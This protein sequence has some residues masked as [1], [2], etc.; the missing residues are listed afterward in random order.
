MKAA[1]P[2]WRIILL[3]AILKF[4][5]PF[6]LQS[7]AYELQRDEYLYYQQGQH[8]GLGYLENPP[9]L[10]YLGTISSWLGGSEFWIKFWPSLV[11]AMTII[12]TCLLTSE[13]GGKAF[14]QMIAGIGV[15][16]GAYLRMHSLFQPNILDI[17]FWTLAIYFLVRFIKSTETEFLYAFIFSLALGWWSKYSIVFLAA[18]IFIALLLSRYR[19]IF[20]DKKM[21]LAI[22]AGLILILPNVWWQYEHRWPLIHHMEELQATQ[23]RFSSPLAFLADQLLYLVPVVFVWLS[24]LV[25]LLRRKEWSFL[26]W[27]Y[28][29]LV[30]L[31]LA[32]RG[33]SYYS[34]GI[35]P[36]LLA[37]G[38]VS[39]ESWT[40]T[41][42][43]LRLAFTILIAAL[44]VPFVPLLLPIW[45]PEKLAA[46]YRENNLE[47]T[48]LLKWEDQRNHPLPQDFADML[49]W[50]ELTEK[51]E[52]FFKSLPDSAKASTFVNPDNYGQAGAF[53]YYGK[54]DLFKKRT[55]T[56][57]G[58]FILWL[59]DSLTFKNVL[60][61]GSEMTDFGFS[62]HFEKATLVDSVTNKLSRQ[63]GDKI[64]YFQN[65]DT[66]GLRML[67]ER[68]SFLKREFG[69]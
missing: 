5:L 48:G 69:R 17:F 4:I 61:T 51:T 54:E 44:T 8:L 7:S 31:L 21:Y 63:F 47:K 18:A 1:K 22:L 26:G 9:M 60:F 37:A 41:R 23:L 57:N 19:K 29:L 42:R 55:F 46:F 2:Y 20:L 12:I 30:A 50:K 33:K 56:G 58:S 43:S 62:K 38:G 13:F 25:W 15:L 36:M 10:S 59:P 3:L 49:G 16:T 32:G 67:S 66:A 65:I 45:K 64:F 68:V 27:T 53:K 24:G 28:F 39:L 11:G 34:M 14:A 6:I 52:A 35:Y 40:E